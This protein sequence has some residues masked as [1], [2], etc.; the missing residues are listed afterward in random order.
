ML[1]PAIPVSAEGETPGE[2]MVINKTATDNDDGTYEIQ[3]EAYATGEAIISEETRDIPTG[4][5]LVLTTSPGPWIMI[6]DDRFNSYGTEPAA[7]F[8]TA[9][10][11]EGVITSGTNWMTAVM[12]RSQW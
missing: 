8:M 12:L 2:G 11:M 4:I 5:I 7:T 6:F 1:I 10:I 9:A 3:L